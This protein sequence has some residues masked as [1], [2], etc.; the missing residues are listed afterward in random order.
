MFIKQPIFTGRMV[1]YIHSTPLLL[2]GS[3]AFTDGLIIRFMQIACV[4]FACLF[5]VGCSP[6]GNHVDCFKVDDGYAVELCPV[7]VGGLISNSNDYDGRY[8]KFSGVLSLEFGKCVVH[9]D[10]FSSE[11][12]IDEE[13]LLISDKECPDL[14]SRLNEG[15][16]G[17]VD[18]IGKY[19]AGCD[20]GGIVCAG[21]IEELRLIEKRVEPSRK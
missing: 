14:A 13:S 4:I 12:Y 8:V 3:P 19:R 16:G 20:R 11:N 15:N 5:S 10:F 17:V 18:V 6:D 21:E 7:S 9:R 1:G 2:G